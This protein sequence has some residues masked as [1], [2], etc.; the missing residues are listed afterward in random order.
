MDFLNKTFAQ[1]RDLFRSMTVGARI[2]AGLLLVVVVVSVVYLFRSSRGGPEVD[3]M[4]GL[5]VP[6]SQLPAMEAAFDKAGLREYEVR[7]TQI[8]VPRGQQP[9]YMAALADAKVLPPNFGSAL[10][11]AINGGNVFENTK[12]K[13]QRVKFALQDEL[14]LIIGSMPGIESA[15]VF[16]DSETKLGLNRE[17]IATA[18]VVVTPLGDNRLDDDGAAKC[19]HLVSSAI[20]GLKPES[21]TVTDT[22]GR[23]FHGGFG[24]GSAADNEYLAVKR[25]Y[26]QS[27]KRQILDALCY[28]PNVAVEP[29]VILDP[30]RMQRSRTEK[31]EPKPVAIRESDTSS[32]RSNQG[33]A[34]AGRPGF[35]S[36]QPNR[37]VTLAATG[38]GARQEDEDSKSE[39]VYRPS[40]EIVE[41][42]TPGLIPKRVTVSVGIPSSYFEKIWRE[43]NPAKE[44]EEPKT[45]DKAALEAIR[46]EETT[47]IQKYV[48]NILPPVEGTADAADLVAVT[49][50]QDI[51]Q[52]KAPETPATSQAISWLAQYWP[53]LG[54]LGLALFG[55]VMLRSMVRSVPP[56]PAGAPS[57][58]VVR[59]DD[60]SVDTAGESEPAREKPAAKRLRRFQGSGKSLRDEV[61][62]IVKEDP[63]VAANILKSW[64][65][66]VG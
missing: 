61:A 56:P 6:A 22:K 42:E 20:V 17:K 62:D 21:V 66:H 13:D 16:F 45:P 10:R 41:K 43:L 53:T 46:Q 52:P 64:I 65:G 30:Q 4:H 3:L 19:R 33:A 26:E 57:L 51:K 47:K 40:V 59:A 60:S 8:R 2:T 12:T 44:G 34:P 1:L 5:P 38:G 54:T 32:S 27:L 39:K 36:Q 25:K 55:L 28:I 29:S 14:A 48:A 24:G 35:E 23:T 9:K 18:S 58:T 11:E 15:C 31:V 37:G 50:F 7:G 63:D 49:T